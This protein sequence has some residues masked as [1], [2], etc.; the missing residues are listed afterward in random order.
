MPFLATQNPPES[1]LPKNGRKDG[2]AWAR[3]GLL[4]RTTPTPIRSPKRKI[5]DNFQD[6]Y[7]SPKSCINPTSNSNFT[8]KFHPISTSKSFT[9]LHYKNS[10]SNKYNNFKLTS[11]TARW[12]NCTNARRWSIPWIAPRPLSPPLPF[13]LPPS[14][15]LSL[16]SMHENRRKEKNTNPC[17]QDMT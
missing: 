17:C 11:S 7:M 5:Y 3:H 1:L 4:N 6:I 8:I 15:S 16:S 9:K 13:S 2:R 14:L 10:E 12:R